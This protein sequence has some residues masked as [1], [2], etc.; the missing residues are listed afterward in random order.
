MIRKGY[1]DLED[2]QLHYRRVDGPGEPVVCLHQT[3]SSSAMYVRLMELLAGSHG[4]VAPD[5]PGFGGSFDPAG[6]P[7]IARYGE[8]VLEAVDALGVGRFHVVGHH[9][10]A[11]LGVYLAAEHPDRIASLAIIGP[12]Y[13]DAAERE[14][15][16][17][18]F[19][20]PI[21]P[22]PDGLYL[23]RTWD[24]LAGLG[25]DG[26]LELH[27]RELIDTVRAYEARSRT[28]HAVWDFDFPAYLERVSC[29]IALMCAEDDVNY[30]H[31][32]RAVAARPDAGVFVLKGSNFE[33]DLDSVGTAEAVRSFLSGV[34]GD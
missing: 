28:Y 18:R 7:S 9:T 32:D 3:A 22:D 21:R 4:V 33:P 30:P 25:V 1:V 6:S 34:V 11:V 24:Y 20:E 31:F 8:W 13:L 15:F 16:R 5:T 14:L 2:G 17:S 27:H 29:P 10:G 12:V 23:K 26:D 19:S